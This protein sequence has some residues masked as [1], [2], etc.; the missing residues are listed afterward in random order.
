MEKRNTLQK[1]IILDAVLNLK[2]HPTADDVY[3]RVIQDYP[4]VSKATVY[5]NLSG[6][7]DDNIIRHI[8]VCDGADRFD[9]NFSTPHNHIVCRKCGNFC[10]APIINTE[11][12]D[13]LVTMQTSFSDIK[14]EIVYTGICPDCQIN[15]N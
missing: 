4:N 1:K 12:I 14:H 9:H 15:N 10:D 7:A 6:L 11:E 8:P 3:R 5:R 13:A 2:N